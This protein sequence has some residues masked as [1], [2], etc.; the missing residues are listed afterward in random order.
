LNSLRA[1]RLKQESLHQ[2]DQQKL[3][4]E[5]HGMK[6]QLEEVMKKLDTSED[7]NHRLRAMLHSIAQQQQQM[8]QKQNPFKSNA[9]KNNFPKFDNLQEEE[10]EDGNE[11]LDESFTNLNFSIGT[12]A[13][14]NGLQDFEVEV[15]PSILDTSQV[16]DS[17]KTP[18]RIIATQSKNEIGLQQIRGEIGEIS[19]SNVSSKERQETTSS[20]EGKDSHVTAPPTVVPPPS[21]PMMSSVYNQLND[22]QLVSTNKVAGGLFH[23][24]QST[25][26]SF[27]S[28]TTKRSGGDGSVMVTPGL[29]PIGGRSTAKQQGLFGGVMATPG[30]SPIGDSDKTVTK[31]DEDEGGAGFGVNRSK[32]NFDHSINN[33]N[34]D[35]GSGDDLNQTVGANAT[36]NLSL[37][38]EEEAERERSGTIGTDTSIVGVEDDGAGSGREE[39]SLSSNDSGVNRMQMKLSR[40]TREMEEDEEM[41]EGASLES[42]GDDDESLRMFS[43]LKTPAK[44]MTNSMNHS[45]NES[46]AHSITNSATKSSSLAVEAIDLGPIVK[47]VRKNNM[48]RTKNGERDPLRMSELKRETL[49]RDGATFLPP[50]STKNALS[51]STSAAN[52]NNGKATSINDFTDH[53]ALFSSHLSASQASF[54]RPLSASK[55]FS[56]STLSGSRNRINQNQPNIGA[57]LWEAKKLGISSTATQMEYAH[58]IAYGRVKS[59]HGS[60]IAGKTKVATN[61]SSSSAPP[62]DENY[63]LST[64]IDSAGGPLNAGNSSELPHWYVH[65]GSTR[66]SP[67]SD[68]VLNFTALRVD[69]TAQK[70]SSGYWAKKLGLGNGG[71]GVNR[72]GSRRTMR[73]GYESRVTSV[74]EQVYR[75]RSPLSNYNTF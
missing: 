60:S 68:R 31:Q 66:T 11:S 13:H 17:L 51:S 69:S 72:I 56:A 10:V 35:I 46:M 39:L 71:A 27:G 2:Q 58:T 48:S 74:P 45:L 63:F 73:S 42:V 36:R 43:P 19:E 4:K 44:A 3:E 41:E 38:L 59:Y 33:L 32:N 6:K 25:T 5:I 70:Y 18:A 16:V 49:K 9:T 65:P 21:T 52:N 20:D 14:F 34:N 55:M 67:T 26:R 40:M 57:A 47:Q 28:S 12:L 62:F 8:K 30:L 24:P 29:S 7:E 61:S 54:I 1:S 53:T 15:P 23:T 75:Y 22:I 64:T 37:V 50:R